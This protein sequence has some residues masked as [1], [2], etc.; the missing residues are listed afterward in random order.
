MRTTP[1]R[2]R[3]R[4]ASRVSL[5]APSSFVASIFAPSASAFSSCFWFFVEQRLVRI[6]AH[7]DF[8]MY[9]D[10]GVVIQWR[11]ALVT[12]ATRRRLGFL[13]ARAATGLQRD[14]SGAARDLRA[15]ERLRR[16]ELRHALRNRLARLQPERERRL[17]DVGRRSSAS[18]RDRARRVHRLRGRLRARLVRL[19]RQR[20][21]RLRSAKLH[22]LR[23][24]DSRR[25]RVSN[26]RRR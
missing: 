4:E 1:S 18:H 5:V 13:Q 22:R 20:R 15:G 25:K 12:P 7:L 2:R 17:R 3:R 11:R 24:T 6:F 8:D 16:A 21:E 23:I 19:R 26:A 10:S 9:P 14:R